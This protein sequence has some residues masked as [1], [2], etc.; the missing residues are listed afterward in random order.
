M[1]PDG[2]GRQRALALQDAQRVVRIGC[3]LAHDA[4]T[5][6]QRVQ[7]A[8]VGPGEFG[9]RRS[10]DADDRGHE[11]AGLEVVDCA[12]H[13]TRA[14]LRVAPVATSRAER[15]DAHRGRRGGA[16]ALAHRVAQRE[17]DAV[18]VF[19]VIEPIAA[20]VVGRQHAGRQPPARDAG[21]PRREQLE[22][23]L[24]GGAR[25]RCPATSLED[26]REAARQL[27]ARRHRASERLQFRSRVVCR[28]DHAQG[29]AKNLKRS[30]R[31][32]RPSLRHVLDQQ[33]QRV[34]IEFGTHRPVR[35]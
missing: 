20:D 22:L 25:L 21:D 12:M 33:T 28:E 27:K 32:F 11:S 18:G 3:E 34:L 10:P 30:D 15:A 23:H 16:D 17:P 14:R 8:A 7:M 6:Q 5:G 13:L 2:R 26:V 35:R 31:A 1:Q 19:G 24:G 29:A 9:R 4:V